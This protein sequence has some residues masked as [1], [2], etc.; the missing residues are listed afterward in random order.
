M[1]AVK[2]ILLAL[3]VIFIV[4]QFIPAGIPA[5]KPDDEKSITT[6]GLAGDSVLSVLRRSCFDC[7][8]NQV[9]FPWYARVA[10]SSWFLAG[11]I[12][13][14]K[15]HLNFSEWEAYSKRKKIGLLEDVREEIES[16]GMPLK[17]YLIIHTDARL[18]AG[19]IS[20]LSDWTEKAAS[21]ILE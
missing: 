12:K 4:I 16:G 8:S 9:Q 14:G 19:D 1:K 15:S 5:N 18:N 7:H 3:A 11:H 6:T 17:S 20:A 13:N 2:T 10:P 21:K